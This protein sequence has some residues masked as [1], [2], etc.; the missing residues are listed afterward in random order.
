MT[1]PIALLSSAA[2]PVA[3]GDF[4]VVELT[5]RTH[6]QPTVTVRTIA[7]DKAGNLIPS[8]ETKTLAADGTT[9]KITISQTTGVLFYVSVDTQLAGV[10]GGELFA[11]V[12]LQNG[13]VVNSINNLYLTSGYVATGSPL[14]YPAQSSGN[15]STQWSPTIN[16][17][18]ADPA[19]GD[20]LSAILN[21]NKQAHLTGLSFTYTPSG[22]AAARTLQISYES[23]GS[24]RF[25][26]VTPQTLTPGEPFFISGVLG[27]PLPANS[28]VTHLFYVPIPDNLSGQLLTVNITP[29]DIESGDQ[30]NTFHAWYYS[31]ASF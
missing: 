27:T 5:P 26:Y 3:A 6:F 12:Y 31:Q 21:S 30:L 11:T 1:A 16:E 15:A 19:A 14:I 13:S 17:T 8:A 23:D 29:T 28:I 22:L 4:L 25:R 24:E 7:Q 20:P 18:F 9:Q 10:D 2:V